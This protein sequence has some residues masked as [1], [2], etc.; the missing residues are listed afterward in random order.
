MKKSKFTLIELL[1]V[2][3]II[4][5]LASMLLPALNRARETAKSIK[6]LGNLKQIGSA[7]MFYADDSDGSWP[8]PFWSYGPASNWYYQDG[9]CKE[10]LSGGKTTREYPE[11][12]ICPTFLKEKIAALAGASWVGTTYGENSIGINGWVYNNPASWAHIPRARKRSQFKQSSRGALVHENKGHGLTE[13]GTS[14]GTFESNPNFPHDDRSNLAFMDGHAAKKHMREVP[15]YE[16]YPST[17]Q[18]NRAN[19]YMAKGDTP[20]RADSAT[21]TIVGL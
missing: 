15:C 5:I 13:Y 2:I 20:Y 8:S 11:L 9:I 17:G 12:F 19:T 7:F 10:Y 18:S 16:S 14:S 4:A 21:F 6:C 1:V 3:A